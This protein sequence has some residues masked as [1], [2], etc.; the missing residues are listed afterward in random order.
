MAERS[1]ARLRALIG[2]ERAGVD[3]IGR[4][5]GNVVG[6]REREG[7]WHAPAIVAHVAD[8]SLCLAAWREKRSIS[9]ALLRVQGIEASHDDNRYRHLPTQRAMFK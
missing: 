9:D 1:A 7:G 5:E 8:N 6:E 2:S 3:S 4:S